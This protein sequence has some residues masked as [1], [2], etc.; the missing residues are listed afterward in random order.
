MLSGS[1][2]PRDGTVLRSA[3]RRAGITKTLSDGTYRPTDT[4]HV[5]IFGEVDPKDMS[6][7]LRE[8]LEFKQ[9]L[10]FDIGGA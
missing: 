9:L 1:I 10:I 8:A 3:G 4:D 2:R 6:P 5:T 7:F